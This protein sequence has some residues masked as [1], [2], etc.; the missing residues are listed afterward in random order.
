MIE[1]K[2]IRVLLVDDHEM[3]RRGLATM[4]R[5]FDDMDLVGEA[6]DGKQAIHL[7]AQL[8]PDVVLMDLEMP[9]IDGIAATNTIHK[10]F[11]NIHII[12][13]TSFSEKELIR[14]ALKAGAIGY[15]LKNVPIQQL[16]DAIRA[17]YKGKPTL[18]P[19]ATQVLINAATKTKSPGI[20]LTP[21]E[22][23][24][25]AL[26]V[27]GLSNPEIAIRL[28]LS[29]ST[30]K[31]HVSNLFGKLGVASRTEA[32]AVALKDKLI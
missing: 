11:P 18:A 28:S 12:A 29:R 24:T 9:V 7:C 2:P 13:L 31:S 17:A 1:E 8:M 27:E 30:V 20:D 4:L 15:L 32:V 21:R 3:V 10:R 22:R 6:E 5:A 26:L 23:E 16:V 14:D 19:E 25:L